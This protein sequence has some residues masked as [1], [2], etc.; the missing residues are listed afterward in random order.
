[1]FCNTI[2]D[3]NQIDELYNLARQMGEAEKNRNQEFFNSLLSD[4][5]TFRRASGAIVDKAT[6]LAD[7]RNPANSYDR[8]E[9]K[10]IAAQVYE[11]LAV[12]TLLV[13]AKGMREGK[14]FEG[15]FRNVRIFLV[16]PVNDPSWQL[17]S[18]FNVKVP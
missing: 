3:Q 5:L 4:K 16:E 14:P 15:I 6:F 12:V 1:M 11:N 18:W 10:H 13:D 7:L 2:S 9:S 8:L 17:H